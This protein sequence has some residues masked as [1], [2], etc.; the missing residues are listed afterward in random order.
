MIPLVPI[1]GYESGTPTDTLIEELYR[2][3]RELFPKET[4]KAEK[5]VMEQAVRLGIIRGK[6][7]AEEV[8]TSP[9]T[10]ALG[11]ALLAFL[12]TRRR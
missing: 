11:G 5:W 1:V 6:I 2:K 3:A 7:L 10:W 12:L 4:A 9:W 8:A